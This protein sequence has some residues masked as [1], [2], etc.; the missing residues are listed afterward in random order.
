MTGDVGQSAQVAQILLVRVW[1]VAD[2][3]G[4]PAEVLSKM[5]WLSRMESKRLSLVRPLCAR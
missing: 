4:P 3:S 5:P 1:V 2:I